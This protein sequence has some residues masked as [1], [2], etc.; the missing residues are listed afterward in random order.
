M[1]GS[2]FDR[3]GGDDANLRVGEHRRSVLQPAPQVGVTQ[4]GNR[5]MFLL[6]GH[7]LGT[8]NDHCVLDLDGPANR[9]G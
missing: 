3:H 5:G 1:P 7:F 2:G 8:D 9:G 4:N 6:D